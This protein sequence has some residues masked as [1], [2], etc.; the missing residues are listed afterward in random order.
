MVSQRCYSVVS[1]VSQLCYNSSTEVSGLCYQ[2]TGV[3]FLWSHNGVTMV[4]RR[5]YDSVPMECYIA[6][7]TVGGVVRSYGASFCSRVLY[8]RTS[9]L[10]SGHERGV[11]RWCHDSVT[12]VSQWCYKGVP[13]VSQLWYNSVTVVLQWCSTGGGVCSSLVTREG[14]VAT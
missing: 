2:R 7:Y 10:S 9:V 12:M 1:V 13:M 11:L 5:C 4:S 6:C 3:L 14:G 8:Q